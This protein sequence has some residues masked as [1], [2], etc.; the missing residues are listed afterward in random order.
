MRHVM[1][2]LETMGKH[3]GCAI[4]SI[5]A[6]EFSFEH[7]TLGSEFYQTIDLRNQNLELDADTV[8]WWIA[9]DEKIRHEI[10]AATS[11]LRAALFAYQ[12]WSRSTDIV[13]AYGASFDFPILEAAFRSQNLPI[14]WNYRNL[15]C[16]RTACEMVGV[17]VDRSGFVPH[18]AVDD[19][20]AQ[21]FA[22]MRA[23]WRV[24]K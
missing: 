15:R 9:Q 4:V 19:A 12:S 5:G 8:C 18:N 24:V 13:W 7:G 22:V 11:T 20:K 21:A 17:T 16:A 14:P 3:A 2:D 10:V 6:V 23:G 1:I